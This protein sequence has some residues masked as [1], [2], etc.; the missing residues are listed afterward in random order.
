MEKT[1]RF[2]QAEIAKNVDVSSSSKFFSLKLE[3]FGPYYMN[4]TRNGR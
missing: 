4:Y 3:Q 1:Y 2:K